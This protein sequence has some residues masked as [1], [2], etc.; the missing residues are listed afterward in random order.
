MSQGDESQVIA[1]IKEPDLFAIQ[2]DEST[3]ITGKSS[4]PSIQQVCLY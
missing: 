1:N 4:T 3:D 2:L